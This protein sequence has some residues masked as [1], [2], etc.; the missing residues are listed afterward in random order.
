MFDHIAARYDLLNRLLSAGRDIAWRK[1]FLAWLPGEPGLRILDLATGT[2]DV[3]LTLA[4]DPRVCTGIGLDMSS[5]MLGYAARK[6]ATRDLGQ[7]FRLLRGDAAQLPLNSASVDVIT[8]SFGIRNVARVEEALQEMLRVLRPG[9]RAMIME[10]SLPKNRLFRPLYL[11][12]LRHILPR[13]GAVLSGDSTAYRYLN[14]TI[15]SFPHGCDFC[16]LMG[17]AGFSTIECVSLSWGIATLYI[18]Y[19]ENPRG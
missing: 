5:G 19:R 18:G 10:F 6:L 7:R 13:L 1:R 4:A 3:L 8:I 14:Q 17:R 15:E 11:F 2:G 16:R 9:G 12:Y